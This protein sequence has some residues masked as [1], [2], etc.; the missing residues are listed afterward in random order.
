MLVFCCF[1][2]SGGITFEPIC[3]FISPHKLVWCVVVGIHTHKRPL[4]TKYPPNQTTFAHFSINYLLNIDGWFVCVPVFVCLSLRRWCICPVCARVWCECIFCVCMRLASK[5]HKKGALNYEF[6]IAVNVPVTH[7]YLPKCS[8]CRVKTWKS[9]STTKGSNRQKQ[10]LFRVKTHVLWL[11]FC[12]YIF[13]I[14][15]IKVYFALSHHHQ[16]RPKRK[17]GG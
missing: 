7:S 1:A 10:S 14:L 17:R 5:V 9:Y 3:L 11:S 2:I 6:F 15:Y 16:Q 12:F 8:A 4:H 13:S